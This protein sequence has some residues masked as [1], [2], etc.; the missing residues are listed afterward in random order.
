MRPCFL[1]YGDKL[2]HSLINPNQI[3][4]NKI[5]Y[6]DNPYDHEKPLAIEVQDTLTIPL[7]TKGTK[8]FFTTRTPTENELSSCMH[9]ALTSSSEW[10][11]QEVSL[12]KVQAFPSIMTMDENMYDHLLP[13]LGD[14]VNSRRIS[15]A[16]THPVNPRQSFVS[17]ERHQQVTANRLAE[18]FGIGPQ[19]AHA[20]LKATTQ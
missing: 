5:N 11:P 6:W 15:S 19:R 16:D 14:L 18:R 17:N 20:T 10:N 2:D 7:Q 9:V 8:I 12:S 3:R 4:H 13:N 1:F